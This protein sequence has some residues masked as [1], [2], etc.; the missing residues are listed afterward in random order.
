[1]CYL[2]STRT[3]QPC[4]YAS[5]TNAREVV[6]EFVERT[7]SDWKAKGSLAVNMAL[8]SEEVLHTRCKLMM[9]PLSDKATVLNNIIEHLG[10]HLVEGNGLQEPLHNRYASQVRIVGSQQITES[11][12]VTSRFWETKQISSW[13]V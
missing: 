13:F 3:S 12:C 10:S 2:D 8:Y 11:P 6:F 1:M 5:R 9:E 4:D 7:P